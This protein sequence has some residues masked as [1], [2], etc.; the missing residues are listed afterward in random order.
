M[1][2]GTA[3]DPA[4]LHHVSSIA[5]G[6]YGAFGDNWAADQLAKADALGGP[7]RYVFRLASG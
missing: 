7:S 3:V 4:R 6:S 1:R 5:G 2:W